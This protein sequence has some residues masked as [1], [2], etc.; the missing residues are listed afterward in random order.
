MKLLII[1]PSEIRSG[2]EEYALTIGKAAINQGWEV[3]AAFPQTEKTTSL[4]KDFQEIGIT[5]HPLDIAP[6]AGKRLKLFREHIPHCYRSFSL[7]KKVNPDVVHLTVPWPFWCFDTLVTCAVLN[8]PTVV[9]F[10]LFPGHYH[11]SNLRLKAYQWAYNRRQKWIAISN[12]NRDFISESFKIPKEEFPVVYNGAKTSSEFLNYSPE[13]T[14]NLRNQVRQEIGINYDDIILLTVGRLHF[15]KGYQ[16]LV[17]VISPIIQ[18]FNHAKFVWVG[19]GDKREYLVEQINKHNLNNH[20]I[21]L[22][23]RKDVPRLMKA[24]DLF[25]FPTYIEGGQSFVVSEAMAYNLPII[26]SDASGIPEILDN[27][28]HGLLFAKGDKEQ[29]KQAI[30]WALKNPEAMQEMSK[31]SALRLQDFSEEKMT[32]ETLKIIKNIAYTTN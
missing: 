32:E 30:F 2:A 17:K 25:V 11:Y 23:Y 10:Q 18:E 19:E 16:D 1:F 7:L 28:I 5:Y 26:T 6:V 4:I 20:V 29:L 14:L 9:V 12:N 13:D 27:K 8:I 3:N 15:H 31:N 22:G 24:S 21:L